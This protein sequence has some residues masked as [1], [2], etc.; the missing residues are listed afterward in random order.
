MASL[1][2]HTGPGNRLA[3]PGQ[4]S[5]PAFSG[6]RAW[7]ERA[8]MDT[9]IRRYEK[10]AQRCSRQQVPF[11]R[12]RLHSGSCEQFRLRIRPKWGGGEGGP[13]YQR[14]RVAQTVNLRAICFIMGLSLVCERWYANVHC[15]ENTAQSRQNP[16]LSP[17]M[18]LIRNK[19]SCC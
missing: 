5:L 12:K 6:S 9:K 4:S 11:G 1:D 8:V 10:F 13:G 15:R 19:S 17:A 7:I 16:R 3:A 14:E 2:A 18:S